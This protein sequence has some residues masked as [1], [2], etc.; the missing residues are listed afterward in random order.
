MLLVQYGLGMGVNLYLRVPA[1][2]QH[3][4]VATALWRASSKSPVTLAVHSVYGLLLVLAAINVL[5]R[6]LRARAGSALAL[7]L[8]GLLAI[9]AAGVSGLVFVDRGREGASMSMAILTGIA[10]LCYLLNLFLPATTD[11]ERS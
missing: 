1:G 5:V 7:S 3:Q 4:G 8:L 9:V 10:L 2:D 11:G 6:A